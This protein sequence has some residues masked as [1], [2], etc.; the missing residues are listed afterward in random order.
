MGRGEKK[1]SLTSQIAE[2]EAILRKRGAKFD[3]DSRAVCEMRNQSLRAVQKT[4]HWLDKHQGHIR[5]MVK[6]G[7]S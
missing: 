7:A 3:G 5:E 1:V 6:G 4:L 2:I